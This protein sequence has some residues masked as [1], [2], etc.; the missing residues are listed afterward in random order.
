L[1]LAALPG[2]KRYERTSYQQEQEKKEEAMNS[3]REQ[4][5]TITTKTYPSIG[6][7]YVIDLKGAQITDQTFQN[8]KE[9]K[10]VTELDLS[11]SS[12]TDDQMDQL[13]DVAYACTSLD[14]SNTAVTDAGLEKLTNLKVCIYLN[15]SRTKVTRAA[16]QRFEKEHSTPRKFRNVKL[17]DMKIQL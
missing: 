13:N 9:L 7:G 17:P 8:M 3:L 2:C 4:G 14:L 12:L 16:V 15:L 10:R 5:A 1:F 6:N 11:K